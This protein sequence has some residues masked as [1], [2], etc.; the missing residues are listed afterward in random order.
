M[1]DREDMPEDLSKGTDGFRVEKAYLLAGS[2]VP[3]RVMVTV[4]YPA[5]DDLTPD[6]DP[7]REGM[8][9]GIENMVMLGLLD[10]VSG[11][12]RKQ[13]EKYFPIS[14]DI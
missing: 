11:E 4:E 7:F 14:F 5:T 1:A 6:E 9:N 13:I 2:K 10:E 8:R 12:A 3:Y